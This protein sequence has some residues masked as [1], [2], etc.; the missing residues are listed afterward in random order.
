MMRRLQFLLCL[1]IGHQ[2]WDLAFD[3]SP[4]GTFDFQGRD[5]TPLY[6]ATLC[7]RCLSFY[8]WFT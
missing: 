4:G 1:I 7:R 5:G 6:K 3:H 8:G 2:R